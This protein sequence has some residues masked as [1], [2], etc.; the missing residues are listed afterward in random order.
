MLSL[1]SHIMISHIQDNEIA[2]VHH[3]HTCNSYI[4]QYQKEDNVYIILP[5]IIT[6][7]GELTFAGV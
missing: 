3:K 4:L 2:K 5:C 1:V 6:R 7:M